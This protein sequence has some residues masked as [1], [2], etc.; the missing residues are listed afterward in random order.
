MNPL[1]AYN[2]RRKERNRRLVQR[3]LADGYHLL[4]VRA[5]GEKGE[6]REM[7]HRTIRVAN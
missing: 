1:Q 5:T 4:H 7:M 6:T 3:K 2:R